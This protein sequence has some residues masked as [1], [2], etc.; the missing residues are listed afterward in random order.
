MRFRIIQ[1]QLKVLIAALLFAITGQTICQQQMD[2]LY[3][4]DAVIISSDSLLP[5]KNSHTVSKYTKWGAISNNEGRFKLYVTGK[6]SLLV[7]SIGFAPKIV[8][9]SND[10][11]ALDSIYE[12][13][14]EKD[15]ISINEVI[16]RGYYDYAT[17]KQMVVEMKPI[18]LSQFFPDWEGTELL[19]ME[20]Q[21]LSFKGPIQAL[22]DVFNHS[23]RLQRKLIKNRQDY[24]QIM[25]QMGRYQDTIPAIPEH[26]QVLPH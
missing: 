14:L 15:T 21:T 17:M 7:T 3:I 4:L 16:I 11:F 13:R 22:Y 9:T 25:I 19:Y 8:I 26:M 23:A 24:N 5:I 2:S 1:Q 18:D 10:M 20:P 12:I 6:D